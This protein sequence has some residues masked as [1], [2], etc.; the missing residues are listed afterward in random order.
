MEHEWFKM[1]DNTTYLKAQ[2][3]TEKAQDKWNKVSDMIGASKTHRLKKI[4]HEAMMDHGHP[5][6]ILEWHPPTSLRIRTDFS[7]PNLG[8][9][10]AESDAISM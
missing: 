10:L 3:Y 4:V 8:A 6:E 7:Y 5:G 1:A 9:L 2:S